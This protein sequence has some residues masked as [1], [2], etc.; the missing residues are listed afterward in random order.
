MQIGQ[1][2][3]K[4]ERNEIALPLCIGARNDKEWVYNYPAP[5]YFFIRQYSAL[6]VSTI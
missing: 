6:R 3:L 4:V 5:S 2:L 1:K